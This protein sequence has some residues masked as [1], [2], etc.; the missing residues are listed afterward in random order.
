MLMVQSKAKTVEAYI[1]EASEDRAPLLRKIRDLARAMLSDHEETMKWG[2]P[3]YARAGAPSF[4]FAEQKQYVSLYFIN[5][6]AL[7]KNT[8][9]LAT[10]SIGKNCI[11][12]R[13]STSIDWSLLER[14]L[15]DTRDSLG[16]HDPGDTA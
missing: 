9:A 10:L 11:R 2:M 13:K 1:S 6:V 12:L 4:G 8:D 7:R 15:I 5:P 16:S 3:V 14:L